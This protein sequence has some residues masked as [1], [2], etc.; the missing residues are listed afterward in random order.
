MPISG[1]ISMRK[2]K[3]GLFPIV[4]GSKFQSDDIIED[5][6]NK[7]KLIFEEMLTKESF[8]HK[9]DAKYCKFCGQ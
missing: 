5:F 9:S 4:F 3:Q 2:I 7:I 1:I 8:E 6:E